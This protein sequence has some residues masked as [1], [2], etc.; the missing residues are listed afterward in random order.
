[1][2]LERDYTFGCFLTR[3]AHAYIADDH[4]KA[5]GWFDREKKHHSSLFSKNDEGSETAGQM[6]AWLLVAANLPV[7]LTLLIK[8]TNTF[9]PMRNGLK[10]ALA[11]FNR[12]QK[13]HLI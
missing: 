7:V 11:R 5:K 8:W 3:N 4:R 9:V 6:A 2:P 12:F 1:M 10:G 13:K